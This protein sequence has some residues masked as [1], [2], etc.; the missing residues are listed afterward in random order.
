MLK[1]DKLNFKKL[2]QRVLNEDV[3]FTQIPSVEIAKAQ[4]DVDMVNF[5]TKQ[6]K[7]QKNKIAW[8]RLLLF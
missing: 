2:L 1:Q 5:L 6:S 7:K 4:N 8:M 3:F